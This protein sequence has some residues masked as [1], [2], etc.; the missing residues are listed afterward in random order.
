MDN[1]LKKIKEKHST[2]KLTLDSVH[3]ILMKEYGYIPFKEIAGDVTYT[4]YYVFGCKLPFMSKTETIPQLQISTIM[5]LI[6]HISR[7][8]EELKKQMDKHGN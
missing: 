5:S 2:S 6:K 8:G 1:F 4:T 7:D 3:H